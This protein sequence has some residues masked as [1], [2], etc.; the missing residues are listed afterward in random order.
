MGGEALSRA[1]RDARIAGLKTFPDWAVLSREQRRGLVFAL[2]ANGN[3]LEEVATTVG[4]S[5]EYTRC[6]L[7]LIARR[8]QRTAD[9]TFAPKWRPRPSAGTREPGR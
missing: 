4:L 6:L 8:M 3:T 7:V 1:Q 2:R 9:R 5:R